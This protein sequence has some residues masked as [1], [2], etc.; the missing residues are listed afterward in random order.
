MM[1]IDLSLAESW[2]NKIEKTA[3]AINRD[4]LPLVLFGCVYYPAIEDFVKQLQVE[5]AYI[6][7]NNPSKKNL[8][9]Y[10][11]TVITPNELADKYTGNYNVLIL[12]PFEDAI[13]SQLQSLSIPPKDVFYLDFYFYE[14]NAAESFVSDH[15]DKFQQVFDLLENQKS[16]DVYQATVNYWLCRNSACLKPIS[17]PRN[18][19]YFAE[20]IF[21][22]SD[23]EVFVD[24]GAFTGDTAEEFIK[25]C[26]GKYSKIYSFEP[27]PQNFKILNHFAQQHENMAAYPF[28]LG[29]CSKTVFFNSDS[30][31]SKIDESGQES[32]KIDSLDHVLGD[33]ADITFFKLDVEGA[34]C[35]ALKGAENL[36]KRCKPKLA[37]CT[38]HSIS[39]MVDVPLLIKQIEPR[40]SL[41]FRH[42][43]NGI[44]ETVCFATLPE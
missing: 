13:R 34:E 6:C 32:V 19:Q 20:D 40:Y 3:T 22:L 44:V 38:Y 1:N 30:S 23:H 43:T 37:V 4:K 21:S 5:V 2:R 41:Q 27:E 28:G 29:D 7:D 16:K 10:G 36:I 12:V 15:M 39:D 9:F 24:G 42:Y 26:H 8:S 25:R 31:S 18:T 17:L 14:E 11:C 35:S 33:T